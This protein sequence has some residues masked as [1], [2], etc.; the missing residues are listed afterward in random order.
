MSVEAIEVTDP[1]L[2]T[3]VQDLGRYGYQRFGVPVSGAMDEF[4]L[5]AANLLVGNDP[6]AA[7]LEMSVLGPG[8]TFLAPCRLAITGADLSANLDQEPLPRW[9]PIEVPQGSA[10]SFRGME[11]GMRSYLAVAGGIDVPLVMGSRSTYVKSGI[12]GVQG[13]A[14]K[15]GDVLSIHQPGPDQDSVRRQLPKGLEAPQYGE[16]HEL[17]IILGPQDD[18][19]P[20]ETIDTLLGSRYTVSHDSDRMGYRLDG[21]RLAHLSGAD[22]VSDG[23]PL[24]AIQVS[25]DGVTTILLADRG[26]TGGYT[27]IATVISADL[28]RLAQAVPGHTVSF[29]LTTVEEAHRVLREQRALLDHLSGP[30]EGPSGDSPRLT[31]LVDG[32]GFEVVDEDGAAVS[33]PRLDGRPARSSSHKALATVDG[34]TYEFEVEVLREH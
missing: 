6:G 33:R 11:D 27:K 20:Q 17:R 13:R 7:C 30:P 9:Q 16:E 32:E 25:G 24:G 12:G 21:P 10:L 26:T 31:V 28:G 1:G 4:A 5:R 15:N 23:N 14:L 8:L 34:R 2:L 22:I 18:G 19:F 3:T 29:A